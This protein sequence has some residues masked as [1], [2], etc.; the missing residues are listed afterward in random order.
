[1][2]TFKAVDP[3]LLFCSVSSVG[4][5]KR[6]LHPFGQKLLSAESATNPKATSR[7][8]TGIPG[9]KGHRLPLAIC[10]F[11]SLVWFDGLCEWKWKKPGNLT[12][13]GAQYFLHDFTIIDGRALEAAVV[14]VSQFDVI[15]TQQM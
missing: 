8:S 10:G 9:G 13:R 6:F 2:A 1:M 4:A 11:V 7:E 15:Q 14:E 5:L 12:S 3:Q